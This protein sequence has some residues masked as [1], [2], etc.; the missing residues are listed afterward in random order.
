M[1]HQ[2]ENHPQIGQVLRYSRSPVWLRG[3]GR[4][5]V[6]EEPKKPCGPNLQI[7]WESHPWYS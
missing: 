5:H 7:K 2:P 6:E 4:R 3:V 1:E